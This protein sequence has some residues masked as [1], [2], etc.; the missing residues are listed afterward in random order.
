MQPRSRVTGNGSRVTH[1][2]RLKREA[3]WRKRRDCPPGLPPHCAGLGRRLPVTS[4]SIAKVLPKFRK[5]LSGLKLDAVPEGV[6]RLTRLQSL[7]IGYRFETAIRA[8]EEGK[9]RVLPRTF[10][11]NIWDFGGQEI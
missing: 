4:I 7:V 9:E 10:Q 8:R 3:R 5:T 6:R 1:S 2:K 11:V